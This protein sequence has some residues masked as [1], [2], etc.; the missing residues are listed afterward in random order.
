MFYY[1]NNFNQ[2]IGRWDISNVTGTTFMFYDAKRFN[3]G[4]ISIW[5]T[6][7]VINMF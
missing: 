1:T 3:L 2:D 7:K 4:Y 6:S 5:D